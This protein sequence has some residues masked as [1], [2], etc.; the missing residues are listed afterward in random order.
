MTTCVFRIAACS[1]EINSIGSSLSEV[2]F[3]NSSYGLELENC[4]IA[5]IRHTAFLCFLVELILDSPGIDPVTR[6]ARTYYILLPENK[7]KNALNA[8]IWLVLHSVR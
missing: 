3:R 6:Q 5:A 7:S 1:F 4:N 2:A 8:C